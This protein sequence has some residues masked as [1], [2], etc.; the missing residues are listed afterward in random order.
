[1]PE[2]PGPSGG[3][4]AY[5][6]P[7][8]PATDRPAP[9]SSRP[10]P[11]PAPGDG[12][13]LPPV[14]RMSRPP[15]R[16]RWPPV[17]AVLAVLGLVAGVAGFGYVSFRLGQIRRV[18]VDGIVPAGPGSSQTILLAG[19]DSR[20]DESSAAAQE[21]GS[22]SQVA[23]ARSDVI[24]LIRLN[25]AT[26][27]AA[28][29][30]IPRDLFVPIAGTGSSNRINVAFDSGPTELVRTISSSLGITV[31][32]YAEEDFS[33]LEAL[34]DAIGGVC[35]TFPYP[36]RDGSP[37]GTGNESG[38]NIPTSGRHVLGGAMAL[39]LVRS[40]YYQ[41]EVNGTWQA[42]GTGDIG[43]IQR[44]HVFMRALASKALHASLHNPLTANA[45][46][47]KAVHAVT[48]DRSFTDTGLLRLALNLRNLRP[49]GM[50]S[51]TLPYVAANN[52]ESFGDVLLPDRTQDAAVIAAWMAYGASGGGSPAVSSVPPGSVTVRVLNGSGR[53]GQAA[54]IADGLRRAGFAVS[55][56]ATASTLGNTSSIVAY[57]KGHKAGAQAVAERLDGPVTLQQDKTLT[58]SA[59]VLTTGSQ[60]T[61]VSGATGSGSGAASASP[62]AAAPDASTTPP[63]DPTPC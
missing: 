56:Y 36:V 2:D 39:S 59:V 6:A 31:N 50:P 58:G 47:T 12:R 5:R 16:R 43:R 44:Q 35:M 61:A 45:V 37:T 42:E 49:A 30:S 17:V 38:L 34:T 20:A 62:A 51:W 21:F 23:G 18:S 14:E 26:G 52:Y 24:V 32:H 13:P 55:G 46:L 22:A 9:G 40:R 63:W 60:L 25:P 1:M 7:A 57:A 27:K 54:S 53:A 15:R 11:P 8:S 19:S 29:L 33:G 4:V 3:R 10:A 48:I 28:M 41:Y